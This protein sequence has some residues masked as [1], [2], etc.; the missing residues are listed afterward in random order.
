MALIPCFLV[1][2]AVEDFSLLRGGVIVPL[3]ALELAAEVEHEEGVLELHEHV[4]AVD[5]LFG[6]VF[7]IG[8]IVDLRVPVAV[9]LVHLRLELFSRVAA[10]HIFYA[11]VGTQLLRCFYALNVDDV[12]LPGAHRGRRAVGVHLANVIYMKATVARHHRLRH[13][14]CV[15]VMAQIR[16]PL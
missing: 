1:L 7:F 3:A 2:L 16:L 5:C 12:F 4:A 14:F 6:E 9:V 11:E 15:T 10:W 13:V 8:N